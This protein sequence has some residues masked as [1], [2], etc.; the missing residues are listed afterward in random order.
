MP[1]RLA[2][3]PAP[4]LAASSLRSRAG[5]MSRRWLWLVFLIP[6]VGACATVPT[7]PSV[8]VLPGGGKTYERSH[9]DDGTCRQWASQQ[10]GTSPGQAATERGACL[11][12]RPLP[13]RP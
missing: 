8:M 4:A 6:F 1:G 13:T 11:L 12:G 7:G 9:A 5:D 2:A 10:T 3:G